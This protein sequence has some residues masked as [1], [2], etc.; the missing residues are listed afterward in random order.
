L[1]AARQ[2]LDQ[3]RKS[4]EAG[5]PGAPQYG[6][7]LDYVLAQLDLTGPRSSRAV[8]EI[9]AGEAPV[10]GGLGDLERSLGLETVTAASSGTGFVFSPKSPE[11]EPEPQPQPEPPAEDHTWLL[12]LSPVSAAGDY[13]RFP[14]DV[15]LGGAFPATPNRDG[16]S[17]PAA[18]LQFEVGLRV[19]FRNLAG[20]R[21]AA[22]CP[23]TSHPYTV[24]VPGVGIVAE[25]AATDLAPLALSSPASARTEHAQQLSPLPLMA[26]GMPASL[27]SPGLNAAL[28]P[29]TSDQQVVQE[30][31][32]KI[33]EQVTEQVSEEVSKQIQSTLA[34]NFGELQKALTQSLGGA[35]QELQKLSPPAQAPAADPNS[36]SS[37]VTPA[38]TTAAAAEKLY[39]SERQRAQADVALLVA[40]QAKTA[41]QDE[42]EKEKRHTKE[43]IEEA[44][45]KQKAIEQ[46]LAAEEARA[47][48]LV[49]S[50][51]M[52]VN[53]C[54]A[55]F[56]TVAA[57]ELMSVLRWV[58]ACS[59]P[60]AR[61]HDVV[62][63]PLTQRG[64][65]V[66]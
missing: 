42:L 37:E 10:R 59:G 44:V 5:S 31:V 29:P 28:S 33:T 25:V 11:P 27:R 32:R 8:A 64:K 2:S 23:G 60:F 17:A 40:E 9:A 57:L 21:I 4:T 34:E 55:R 66:L 58:V 20:A 35:V 19:R 51:D 47:N 26:A 38:A 41:A 43:A 61:Y 14:S 36:T 48:E 18:G 12:Q 7:H 53:S 50:F 56:T 24:H 13:S 1:R 45:A 54:C 62:C 22:I 46:R 6:G 15:A 39:N 30:D 49:C 63:R 3:M 16:D 52:R 65:S